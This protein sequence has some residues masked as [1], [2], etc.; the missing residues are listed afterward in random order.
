MT[1]G[2]EKPKIFFG[3]MAQI[4]AMERR[5][6]RDDPRHFERLVEAMEEFDPE[7]KISHAIAAKYQKQE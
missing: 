6:L 3:S 2:A 1:E 5:H 7:G 4:E